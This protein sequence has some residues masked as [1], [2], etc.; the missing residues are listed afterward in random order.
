MILRIHFPECAQLT[1]ICPDQYC[2]VTSEWVC[3]RGWGHALAI[4]A[5]DRHWAAKFCS[6]WKCIQYSVFTHIK[7][8]LSLWDFV[9][10]EHIQLCL[11]TG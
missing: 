6:L 5:I 10:N 2:R 3:L 1:L 7:H 9:E 4:T 11:K 8:C